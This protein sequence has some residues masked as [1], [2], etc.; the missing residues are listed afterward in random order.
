[1]QRLR[2]S[3]IKEGDCFDQSLFLPNGGK[4]CPPRTPLT[5][6]HLQMLR[7][8]S[9]ASV[10]LAD[11]PEEFTAQ[12]SSSI[13]PHDPPAVETATTPPPTSPIHPQPTTEDPALRK[14]RMKEAEAIPDRMRDLAARLNPRLTPCELEIWDRHRPRPLP[15]PD[16]ASL[17]DFRQ[18]LADQLRSLYMQL[19]AGK[20]I[21]LVEF[22]SIVDELWRCLIDHRERFAQLALMVPRRDD[23]LPDHALCV[24][25]LAMATAGQLTL[26]EQ[27]VRDACLAGLTFDVGMMLV[28]SRIRSGGEQLTDIDRGRV[29]RH[30]D[31]S[32]VLLDQITGLPDIVRLAAYQH[33]EREN[34]TGYPQALRG[35]CIHDLARIL[36]VCDVFA[37][38]TG[39]RHYRQNKLPYT[40]ME[41]MVRAAAAGQFDKPTARALVQAAGLF[42]VGS[43]VLLSNQTTAQVVAANPNHL[44]RPTVQPLTDQGAPQGP[45]VNL[46]RLPP[47]KLA[48][49][50]P[51]AA[52]A[53]LLVA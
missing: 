50:R 45:A 40:A 49:A 24:A 30:T 16:Q 2:V 28:P 19:D 11:N 31:Y 12:A 9:S 46:S 23:Y 36:A 44:D 13:D 14:L 47:D 38:I 48:V 8:Q 41:Q 21:E 51:V 25:V 39:P 35:D 3:A 26:D 53:N 20:T 6:A 7:R 17:V 37:A 42:P 33:H 34:S 27:A 29:Q 1:M 32:V 52:P 5:A 43:C 15:W 22:L 4:I 10:F 18:A